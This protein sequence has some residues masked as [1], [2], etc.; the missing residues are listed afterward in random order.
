MNQNCNTNT[1]ATTFGNSPWRLTC[2]RNHQTHNIKAVY[3]GLSLEHSG[4]NKC[5][6]DSTAFVRSTSSNC[7]TNNRLQEETTHS[8]WNIYNSLRKTTL[9][10]PC[11]SIYSLKP[12][13]NLYDTL[14]FCWYEAMLIKYLWN[15]GSIAKSGKWHSSNTQPTW[16]S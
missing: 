1:L 5:N 4:C 6:Y 7:E 3:S 9:Y 14:K 16:K 15:N 11:N 2:T 12:N 8:N 10:T 13:F